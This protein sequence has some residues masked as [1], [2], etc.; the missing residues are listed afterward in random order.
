MKNLFFSFLIILFFTKTNAQTLHLIMLSDYADPKFGGISLADEE[1]MLKIFKTVEWGLG[2]KIKVSYLNSN[3]NMFDKASVIKSLD[4][5]NTKT[6][7]NDI[8]VFFYSGLGFYPPKSKATFPTFKLKDY[9]KSPI[10]LDNIAQIIASK[11]VRLGIVLADCRD[12]FPLTPPV[13]VQPLIVTEDLRKL[14][15]RKLFLEQTGILKIASANKG[16]PTWKMPVFN[17]SAFMY[18]FSE[19]FVH[20]LQTDAEKIPLLS[21]DYILKN[22]QK[23]MENYLKGFIPL[24]KPQFSHWEFIPSPPKLNSIITLYPPSTFIIPTEKELKEQ[25]N[26]LVNSTDSLEINSSASKLSNLFTKKATIEIKANDTPTKQMTIEEYMTQTAKYDKK[27]KRSINFN[28]LDFKRT[29]DFKKF[30]FLSLRE[31]IE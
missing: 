8:I 30:I 6:V 11:N 18:S 28:E 16:N 27:I 21:F 10:S 25:L 24:D 29:E 4:S 19:T 3:N 9:K 2:Y 13:F 15:I 7:P 14:I 23:K 17:I 5:L 22:T 26:I 12:S 20:S 1:E 31:K